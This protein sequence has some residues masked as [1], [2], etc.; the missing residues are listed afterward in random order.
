MSG[1]VAPVEAS[2]TPRVCCKRAARRGSALV[3][4]S[5]ERSGNASLRELNQR[6]GRGEYEWASLQPEDPSREELV[7]PRIV[8]RLADATLLDPACE[9]EHAQGK[10]RTRI[11]SDA[12]SQRFM[13]PIYHLAVALMMPCPTRAYE[14]VGAGLPVLRTDEYF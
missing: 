7:N 2:F 13:Y 10:W 12:R 4:I 3:R 1:T 6:Q 14:N 8:L 9:F 5:R 11:A